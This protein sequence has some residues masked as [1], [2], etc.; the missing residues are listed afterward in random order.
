VGKKGSCGFSFALAVSKMLDA[1]ISR[2]QKNADAVELHRV[3]Q[4]GVTRRMM[5]TSYNTGTTT[6]GLKAMHKTSLHAR[7]YR[8]RKTRHALQYRVCTPALYS[9]ARLKLICPQHG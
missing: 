1:K 3:A 4:R 6:L 7:G 5:Y 8:P 2:Y 9:V